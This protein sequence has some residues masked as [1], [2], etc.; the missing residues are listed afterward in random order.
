MSSLGAAATVLSKQA[1]ILT[2]PTPATQQAVRSA[3]WWLR[4]G[5]APEVSPAEAEINTD[6]SQLTH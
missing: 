2:G 6:R 3:K 1:S 4:V 5:D